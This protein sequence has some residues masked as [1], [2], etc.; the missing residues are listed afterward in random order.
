M[1]RVLIIGYFM[2]IDVYFLGILFWGVSE[3]Y[4]EVGKML[5]YVCNWISICNFIGNWWGSEG[6]ELG[7][8][9]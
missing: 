8:E 1:W 5:G 2:D 9:W 4:I 6:F 7:F 3:S